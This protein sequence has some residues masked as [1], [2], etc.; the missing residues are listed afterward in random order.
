MKLIQFI[1]EDTLM[2]RSNLQLRVVINFCKFDGI[3]WYSF[4]VIFCKS[5]EYQDLN[6]K[7]KNTDNVFSEKCIYFFASVQL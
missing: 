2:F 6:T 3:H 4:D 1:L 7:E 5:L